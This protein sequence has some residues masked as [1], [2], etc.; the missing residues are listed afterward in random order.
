[1]SYAFHIPP[2]S[3]ALP[4]NALSSRLRRLFLSSTSRRRV[5]RVP[6]GHEQLTSAC[7]FYPHR[8]WLALLTTRLSRELVMRYGKLQR[9]GEFI[10]R[11]RQAIELHE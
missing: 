8:L 10:K 6:K 1:M 4:G 5:A 7:P 9:A 11:T 3:Q 2:R